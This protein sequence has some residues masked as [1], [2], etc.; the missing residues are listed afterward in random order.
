MPVTYVIDKERRLVISTASDHVTFEEFK[1]HQDRLLSDPNFIS[2]FNQL[3]DGTR[4]TKLDLSTEEIRSMTSRRVFAPQSKR[5]F[6]ASE[7]AHYGVAR[8]AEVYH[9]TA[10]SASQ[11][12]TFKDLPSALEWLGLEKTFRK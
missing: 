12:R 5:A 7:P 10:K 4:V 6:V 9:E 2:D 11:I 8:M 1:A 3:L